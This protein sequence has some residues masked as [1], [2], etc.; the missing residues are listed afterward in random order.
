MDS[1]NKIAVMGDYDSIYGFASLGLSTFPVEGYEEAS[2]TL[3]NL[4]NSGYGIIYITEELGAL[5]QTQIS[6]Y[7]EV[8]LPAII[9]I[10]GVKGN[11]GDGVMAVR[12]SVEKAVGSDI[13]FGN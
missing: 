5:L 11:T 4:A 9:Q 2:K 13:L 10:P 8:M 7:N 12:R 1:G 3:R 6:K